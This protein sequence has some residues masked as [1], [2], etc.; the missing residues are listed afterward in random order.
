VSGACYTHG[1]AGKRN[2][3]K[4][5]SEPLN[6]REHLEETELSLRLTLYYI[7]GE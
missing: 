2:L 4:V 5:L 7:F 1:M 3:Y 6:R